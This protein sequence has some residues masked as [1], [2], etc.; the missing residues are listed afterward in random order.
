MPKRSRFEAIPD[1]FSQTDARADR[2]YDRIV[3]RAM[4][5]YPLGWVHYDGVYFGLWLNI[6]RSLGLHSVDDR[7]IFSLLTGRLVYIQRAIRSALD[8]RRREAYQILRR[9]LPIELA[10]RITIST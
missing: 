1:R 7:I 6:I 10:Q 4:M 3:N 8:R 9:I 2:R 5:E